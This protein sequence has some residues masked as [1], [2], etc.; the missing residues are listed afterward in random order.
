MLDPMVRQ[1]Q[2]MAF[3][4]DEQ[5][6]GIFAALRPPNLAPPGLEDD[7]RFWMSRCS[8]HSWLKPLITD[9]SPSARP[10]PIKECAPSRQ[11]CPM[12]HRSRRAPFPILVLPKTTQ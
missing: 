12:M 11:F 7:L 2:A 5:L 8:N 6:A 10:G 4:N 3:L 1:A 9:P